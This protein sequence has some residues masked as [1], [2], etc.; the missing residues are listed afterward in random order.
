M[1][2][3]GDSNSTQGFDTVFIVGGI[4]ILLLIIIIIGVTAFLII[5]N[6]KSN[7]SVNHCILIACVYNGSH[8]SQQ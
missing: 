7:K 2:M 5:L 1:S 6:V 3:L 4:I 8:F